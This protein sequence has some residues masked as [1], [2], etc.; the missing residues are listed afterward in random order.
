[1]KV[2]NPF[3]IVV[4]AVSFWPLWSFVEGSE[5][6]MDSLLTWTK[7]TLEQGID[8]DWE[9]EFA[10]ANEQ[11]KNNPLEAAQELERFA[12]LFPALRADSIK[13][14]S[15][16]FLAMDRLIWEMEAYNQRMMRVSKPANFQMPAPDFQ[17]SL[18][19]NGFS[20]TSKLLMLV[21]LT[22]LFV[23]LLVVVLMKKRRESS[24]L[25]HSEEFPPAEF[26]WL[27]EALSMDPKNESL[28]AQISLLNL[29]NK[30]H[31]LTSAF[32]HPNLWRE[33]NASEQSLAAML[34][35]GISTEVII[36]E[37]QKSQGT[38][39][40]LRSSLR[41]KLGISDKEDLQIALQGMVD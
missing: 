22:F 32:R 16:T 8:D 26:D 28:I 19:A 34:H 37:M 24:E 21:S 20:R 11:L 29:H 10:W 17:A 36:Q 23:T 1:M 38:I 27:I 40:N 2:F 25:P 7:T 31:P 9:R 15:G 4:L 13:I 41:K 5:L 39:Y 12:H 18:Q 35:D 3:C 14:P 33:L 30:Q 6:P